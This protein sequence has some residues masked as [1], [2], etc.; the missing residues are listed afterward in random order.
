MAVHGRGCHCPDQR[1]CR[2]LGDEAFRGPLASQHGQTDGGG[3]GRVVRLHSDL[4]KTL[5]ILR[6]SADPP[7]SD[8]AVLSPYSTDGPEMDPGRL[9]RW[10]EVGTVELRGF[11]SRGRPSVEDRRRPQ[12]QPQPRYPR[13]EAEERAKEL[14]GQRVHRTNFV[15][16]A[17][18]IQ[19]GVRQSTEVR[20]RSTT[21]C[22]CGYH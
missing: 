1:L 7:P 2:D 4:S 21:E 17:R 9:S 20:T 8:G 13:H 14:H 18:Q 22:E 6:A 11:G 12:S 15:R 3:D 10:R 5:G 16:F 19:Q